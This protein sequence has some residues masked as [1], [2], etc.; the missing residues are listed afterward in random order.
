[1]WHYI[2]NGAKG[3]ESKRKSSRCKSE[4]QKGFAVAAEYLFWGGAVCA[5]E[6]AVATLACHTDSR[7]QPGQLQLSSIYIDIYIC[8]R[9]SLFG[10]K[11]NL[12]TKHSLKFIQTNLDN[13]HGHTHTQTC[14]QTETKT[15]QSVKRNKQRRTSNRMA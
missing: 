4:L 3:T 2:G 15:L 14:V 7:I 9:D 6:A 12:L 5:S 11:G 8:S 10:N 1:M 13:T